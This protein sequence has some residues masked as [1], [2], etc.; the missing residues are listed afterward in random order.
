MSVLPTNAL[1]E[2]LMQTCQDT[3]VDSMGFLATVFVPVLEGGMHN[4]HLMREELTL[5]T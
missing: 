1:S 2:M 3:K 4:G 5:T